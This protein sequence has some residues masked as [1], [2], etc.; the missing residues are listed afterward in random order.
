MGF[1][2]GLIFGPGIFGGGGGVES[3]RDFIR[4]DFY[5]YLIIPAT[6]NLEYPPWT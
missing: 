3:P 2:V 5:L 6:W 4:I 1:F